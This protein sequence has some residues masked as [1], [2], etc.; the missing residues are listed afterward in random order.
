M[1]EWRK[2]SAENSRL[3]NGAAV[4]ERQPDPGWCVV[5]GGYARGRVPA[6][7]GEEVMPGIRVVI[8]ERNPPFAG[9][10]IDLEN[11][12]LILRSGNAV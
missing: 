8:Q 2:G 11:G 10:R 4:W 6:D 12:Q 7:V 5:F 3:S 1:I 9:G